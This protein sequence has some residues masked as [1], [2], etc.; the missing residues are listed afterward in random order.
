[1]KEFNIDEEMW[2]AKLFDFVKTA[3]FNVQ[4]SSRKYND[5]MNVN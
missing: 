1:M 3:V 4:P 5:S 2:G